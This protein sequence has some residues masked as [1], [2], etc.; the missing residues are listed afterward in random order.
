MYPASGAHNGVCDFAISGEISGGS[1]TRPILRVGCTTLS[2]YWATG[3]AVQVDNTTVLGT[4]E[5]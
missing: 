4:F 2:M 1:M 5:P 3:K